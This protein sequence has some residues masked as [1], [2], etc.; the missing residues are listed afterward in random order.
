MMKQVEVFLKRFTKK[1][2]VE[3][4]FKVYPDPKRKDQFFI[5]TDGEVYT[6]FYD[7]S[8]T[9]TPFLMAEAADEFGVPA[10]K[11]KQMVQAAWNS[12]YKKEADFHKMFKSKGWFLDKEGMGTLVATKEV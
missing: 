6:A 1:Q 2:G 9:E 4:L 11:K 8:L 10:E 7:T 5:N 12:V 3:P